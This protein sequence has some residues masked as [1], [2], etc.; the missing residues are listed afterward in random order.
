MNESL[1]FVV[2][3]YLKTSGPVCI[4]GI[5]FKSNEDL[6]GLSDEAK[7]H[8]GKLL[9]LFYL[10]EDLQIESMTY[11]FKDL[12][13][14]S[15]NEDE[16]LQRLFE[17]QA[18]IA[19][20]YSAPHPAFL[21][22]F[23]TKEH[24]NIYNFRP[25]QVSKYLIWPNNNVVNLSSEKIELTEKDHFVSGYECVLNN[26]AHM[27]V[28][29]SSR[30]YPPPAHF[31][32]NISQDL[33][34]DFQDGYIKKQ[35]PMFSKIFLRGERLTD[36]ENRIFTALRWYNRS[37][38]INITE[39][40]ALMNLAIAFE[41]LLG[42]EQGE[43]VTRRFKDSVSLLV[44]KVNRLDSWLEQFYNARS[45][46]VHDGYTTNFL[47]DVEYKSKN[48][49]SGLNYR[50]LVSYGRIIFKI[51]LSSIVHGAETARELGLASLFITNKERFENICREL[52]QIHEDPLEQLLSL[53]KLIQEIDTYQFVG[54][55][56]LEVKL[57]VASAKLVIEAFLKCNQTVSDE[58]LSKMNQLVHM[59]SEELKQSVSLIHEIAQKVDHEEIAKPYNTD[60]PFYLVALLLKSILY[61]TIFF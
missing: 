35:N 19:Y 17:A 23:L 60:G 6:T 11:A 39:E 1:R 57:V 31:W 9:K 3:P 54:E 55:N 37:I 13:N 16:F 2:L 27:W 42:L 51:C 48:K 20:L 29:E 45:E 49:R 18:L 43:Q 53:N 4:R 10:K 28:T 33:Y 44:G 41:S 40:V 26:E 7:E 5:S 50:S 32:L 56:N 38:T 12:E 36:T 25:K 22:P 58:L 52:K 14:S 34:R 46:I 8:L 59:Q 30:L 61:Y 47:F 15:Q 24:A 21:D